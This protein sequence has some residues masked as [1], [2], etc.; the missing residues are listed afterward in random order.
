M[1]VPFDTP[2]SA[3]EGVGPAAEQLLQARGVYTVYDLLRAQSTALHG[4]AATL[5]SLQEVKDR[6]QIALLVV[7]AGGGP[8]A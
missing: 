7:V 1:A 5:A 3:I 4:A 6:R 2:V 8:Q